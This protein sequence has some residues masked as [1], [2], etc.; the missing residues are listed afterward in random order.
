M[1][2]SQLSRF[3]SCELTAAVLSGHTAG[4]ASSIRKTGPSPDKGPS[5]LTKAGALSASTQAWVSGGC[6]ATSGAI[7]PAMPPILTFT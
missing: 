5:D 2:I 1:L 3:Y 4:I 7:N 6:F